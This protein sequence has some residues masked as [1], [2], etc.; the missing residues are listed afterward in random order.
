MKIILSLLAV[1]ISQVSYSNVT[2]W[3]SQSIKTIYK[4]VR[5]ISLHLDDKKIVIPPNTEFEL[6]EIS[7]LSMIKVHLHKYK[8]NNCPFYSTET[9]L[10]L[11]Q[12]AQ[13]NDVKT[14]VGVNLTKGCHVEVFIDMKEYNS[15]SFL[16]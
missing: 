5:E 8:I 15:M 2:N 3:N 12:I 6:F 16:K 4:S 11:V 7:E 14:S 13:A 1:F 10:Q 9:D